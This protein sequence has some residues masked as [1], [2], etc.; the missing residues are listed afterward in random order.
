M[1]A[2]IFFDRPAEIRRIERLARGL[3]G[4]RGSGNVDFEW[5]EA[6]DRLDTDREPQYRQ[7]PGAT[8]AGVAP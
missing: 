1:P 4:G 5:P 8:I 3:S 6:G 7:F 2:S